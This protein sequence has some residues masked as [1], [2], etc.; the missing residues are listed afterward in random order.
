M[1]PTWGSL[2]SL[3]DPSLRVF[4]A[5]SRKVGDTSPGEG[6]VTPHMNV[7]VIL[8]IKEF[9]FYPSFE[10]LLPENKMFRFL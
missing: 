4:K 2:A 8:G 5:S 9:F 1:C 7:K 6:V 10:S 3:G